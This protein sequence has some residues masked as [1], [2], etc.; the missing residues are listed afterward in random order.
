MLK[1][2]SF[3]YVP[4][5]LSLKQ[6]LSNQSIRNEILKSRE[7][8][9]ELRDIADGSYF[10]SH[11]HFSS[12]PDGLQIIAYYDE[13]ETCNPLGSSSKKFKLGCIFFTLGNVRPFLRSSLKAIFLVALAKSSTIKTNGIDSILEPFINDL[14]QL[15]SSGIT[16]EFSGMQEV[17]RGALLCFLADNLAAHE[18]GG[19]KESFSFALKFCRTCMATSDLS[20]TYF[21][22]S[23]FQLR[24]PAEHSR[25][26]FELDGPD[27]VKHSVE[28]GI[29]R[30]AA[31]E[32]LPYFSVVHGLPHDVMH[33]LMEGVIP[34][35]MRLL[36]NSCITDGFFDV[37]TFNHRLN[38]FDF[39]YTESGDK[40]AAIED[41][42]KIRQSAA[43]MWL[44]ARI[45]PFL[46]GDLIPRDYPQ[47]ECFLKLLQICD[48]CTAPSVLPDTA[49]YLELLIEE[50]HTQFS[51]LYGKNLKMHFMVH[52]PGQIFRF[53]PLIQAWT[54]RHEAKL[55][56]IK[57]AARASNY[58]NVCQTAAK[59]H[60]HLLC[61]YLHTNKLLQQSVEIGPCKSPNSIVEESPEIF[62]LMQ[63]FG[64]SND[65]MMVSHPAFVK[66][67]GNFIKRN[68]FILTSFDVLDPVF[69]KVIDILSSGCGI[70]LV[71][72][73]F[74]TI[75]YDAHY[76][77][78]VI[79][80]QSNVLRVIN[81][82]S[83]PSLGVFHPR[84][85]FDKHDHLLYINLKTHIE[86]FI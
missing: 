82:I 75:Y 71:I 14:K 70:F 42:V 37:S 7:S 11:Q 55:R 53:G 80:Q 23:S 54:M 48:I 33:D 68:V 17:W 72:T 47:W 40:P 64:S 61:Y 44:L 43:Q 51:V 25:Q 50:H 12:D 29:N 56:I 4:L 49:M 74:V 59:R 38:A 63:T 77:A 34:H 10:S 1:R 46:V 5:L 8:G 79:K 58:K 21:N 28:Y 18:L 39:G 67:N 2:D 45:L 30:R 57:R 3:H 35:E 83:V 20:Q 6:L 16:L 36:L 24:T 31:L 84:L 27:R 65:C 78:Y 86:N 66:C 73:E 81:A 19:F 62:S 52:Y 22:E 41:G 9:D 13:V 32:E 76:H 69:C 15:S 60:Q 26:C 85:T